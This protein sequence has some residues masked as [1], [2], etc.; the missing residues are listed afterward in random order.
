MAISSIGRNR[1]R[2]PGFGWLTGKSQRNGQ[3]PKTRARENAAWQ[4]LRTRGTGWGLIPSG[5][6]FVSLIYYIKDFLSEA[7][8]RTLA[9]IHSKDTKHPNDKA[10]L[11][12]I[13]RQYLV[14]AGLVDAPAFGLSLLALLRYNPL[15]SSVMIGSLF[16]VRNWFANLILDEKKDVFIKFNDDIQSEQAGDSNG[17]SNTD[18]NSQPPADSSQNQTPPPTKQQ[19]EP[20]PNPNGKAGGSGDG[21]AGS[22]SGNGDNSGAGGGMPSGVNGNG[23]GLPYT[24][25]PGGGLTGAGYG[26]VPQA[27]G[28]G[29]AASLPSGINISI[30]NERI[31]RN[32]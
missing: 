20:P 2:V 30:N 28:T 24:A 18:N 15:I 4:T 27:S 29:G 5:L 32:G 22:G 8:A 17:S 11:E 14:R 10:D 3:V 1:F 9:K 7:Y 6:L 23:A 19:Q 31:V 16:I 12:T 21:Q 26:Q 25:S 13:D